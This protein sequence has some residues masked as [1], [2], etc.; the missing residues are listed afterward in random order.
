MLANGDSLLLGSRVGR[1]KGFGD[2]LMLDP[3]IYEVN[4]AGHIVW[5]W[6]ASRHLGELGFTSMRLQIMEGEASADYLH[7]NDMQ[8]LGPN[9]WAASGDQRF[10]SDNILI[11]SRN[12]NVLAIISRETGRIVWRFSPDSR[13][14]DTPMRTC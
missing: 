14:A 4:E 10:A 2:R 9:H 8:V 6:R 7:M 1:L 5:T 3:V 13:N 11:S 12:S